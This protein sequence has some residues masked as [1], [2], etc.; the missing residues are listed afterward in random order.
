MVRERQFRSIAGHGK[1]LPC[2]AAHAGPLPC[3][4]KAGQRT[5]NDHDVTAGDLGH[6]GSRAAG[7]HPEVK[8]HR[9][10]RKP[11][12]STIRSDSGRVVQ[13]FPQESQPPTRRSIVIMTGDRDL[14]NSASKRSFWANSSGLHATRRRICDSTPVDEFEGHNRPARRSARIWPSARNRAGTACGPI[15]DMGRSSGSQSVTPA[16]PLG[17]SLP[18]GAPGHRDRGTEVWRH[19]P[20]PRNPA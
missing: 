12:R 7:A 18:D 5:V 13:Q 6:I 9:P 10:R 4:A 1:W 3:H 16:G 14:E 11:T 19:T 15:R 17:A 8:G 20:R 2:Q